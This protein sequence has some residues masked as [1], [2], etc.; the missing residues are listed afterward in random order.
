MSFNL[1]C[2][3]INISLYLKPN[4]PRMSKKNQVFSVPKTSKQSNLS[5]NDANTSNLRKVLVNQKFM[6]DKSK[7]SEELKSQ[8]DEDWDELDRLYNANDLK[9]AKECYGEIAI[10]AFEFL[11]ECKNSTERNKVA[12]AKPKK[13]EQ[14]NDDLVLNKR[15]HHDFVGNSESDEDF[16]EFVG[17]VE[18]SHSVDKVRG[19]LRRTI[20]YRDG[21]NISG[22]VVNDKFEGLVCLESKYKNWFFGEIRTD[23]NLNKDFV[24]QKDGREFLADLDI[25]SSKV[26]EQPTLNNTL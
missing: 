3:T 22:T 5:K 1:I 25:H 14:A 24:Q 18:I 8:K 16:D 6:G 26:K 7:S 23:T 19:N 9:D 11:K 13:N 2:I 21:S 12:K 10:S 4:K 15:S 20:E 17:I